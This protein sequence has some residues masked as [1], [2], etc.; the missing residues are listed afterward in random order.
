MW[1]KK[2]NMNT[3]YAFVSIPP[4][5]NPDPVSARERARKCP[6]GVII[7]PIL[8]LIHPIGLI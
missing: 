5:G 8:K 7:A 1:N 4:G 2:L 6:G 3:L